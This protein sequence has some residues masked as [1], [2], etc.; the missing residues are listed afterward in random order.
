MEQIPKRARR[1]MKQR[2]IVLVPFPFSDQTGK[3]V[4]PALILSNNSF[5]ENS[6]DLILCGIT[7]NTKSSKYSLSIDQKDIE[8]GNL[9]EKS[10]I[11]VE[12]VM[13]INKNLVIKAFA[14][15]KK[16]SYI[17]VTKKLNE[18]VK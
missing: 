6:D 8:E 10:S 16:K 13:K 3:K 9:Y 4:R 12:N 14:K 17:E 2:N 5:N 1:K 7:S 18:L 15:L 11:K